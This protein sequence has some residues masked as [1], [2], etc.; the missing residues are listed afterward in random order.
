MQGTFQTQR[1]FW[2][3]FTVKF[4][5]SWPHFSY[6]TSP[7]HFWFCV[8][9]Q[10][11]ELCSPSVRQILTTPNCT[12]IVPP[13]TWHSICCFTLYQ[14]YWKFIFICFRMGPIK[15]IV[16]ISHE[17]KLFWGFFLSSGAA[18]DWQQESDISLVSWGLIC[19]LQKLLQVWSSE[20]CLLYFFLLP[21][22]W[23]ALLFIFIA[24][25]CLIALVLGWFCVHLVMSYISF[26]QSKKVTVW[27]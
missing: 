6:C 10:A 12:Q 3:N 22:F 11:S 8:S 23:M 24:F 25:T 7:K 13:E 4:S 17:S 27:L 19:M 2:L 15:L 1:Y 9:L 26:S 5:I 14:H 18:Y 16:D 21:S 20:V